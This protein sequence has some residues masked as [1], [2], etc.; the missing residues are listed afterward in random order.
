MTSLKYFKTLSYFWINGEKLNES[1]WNLHVYSFFVTKF[2]AK[3]TFLPKCGHTLHLRAQQHFIK[4]WLLKHTCYRRKNIVT[5]Y[6]EP[7][8]SND[9]Q[10]SCE[11]VLNKVEKNKPRNEAEFHAHNLN[12]NSSFHNTLKEVG[13]K[14]AKREKIN[15]VKCI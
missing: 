9:H 6:I 7:S 5:K 3:W 2:E 14:Y 11:F 15:S 1:L 4:W 13:K 12:S 10:F 8:V